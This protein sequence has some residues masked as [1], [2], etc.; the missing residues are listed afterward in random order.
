MW[1]WRPQQVEPSPRAIVVAMF[2]ARSDGRDFSDSAIISA[3]QRHGDVNG[4][5][6]ADRLSF[7]TAAAVADRREV[8]DWLIAHGA[9]ANPE[10]G[11]HPLK[12][13]IASDDEMMA[14]RMLRAGSTWS[15]RLE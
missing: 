12:A 6:E 4:Y 14:R 13:A 5:S 7:V 1:V 11:L 2:P 8:F 9:T 3:I 10:R 15:A